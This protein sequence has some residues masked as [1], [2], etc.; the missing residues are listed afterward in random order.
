MRYLLKSGIG[1]A[2]LLGVS[3]AC[4][5]QE[6]R[7]TLSGVVRDTSGAVAPGVKVQAT[8][9]ATGVATETTT[10]ANGVYV[11]PYL[12]PGQYTVRAEATGFKTLVR[13]GVEL[14]ISDRVTLNIELEVGAVQETVNV[15]AETPQLEVSTATTGQVIDKR[16]I[17]ELPL[18]EGNPLVL[19]RLGRA[20]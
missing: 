17:Q 10:E 20:S 13:K 6:T 3:S 18:A 16:R 12:L 11:I 9:V 7:A 2:L 5:F 1:L 15:T 8:N 4:A 14:R 19:V